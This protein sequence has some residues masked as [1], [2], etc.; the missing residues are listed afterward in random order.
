M[1]LSNDIGKGLW[2]NVHFHDM[3]QEIQYIPVN[4][5]FEYVEFLYFY[6][7]AAYMYLKNTSGV[8]QSSLPTPLNGLGHEREKVLIYRQK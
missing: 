4:D 3:H 7:S 1:Q 2:I 6:I 5:N 8:V